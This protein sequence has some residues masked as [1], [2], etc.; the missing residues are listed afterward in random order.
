MSDEGSS[1]VIV[2]GPSGLK[3]ALLDVESVKHHEETVPELLSALLREI[4]RDGVLKHPIIVDEATLVVLDGTHR[5]EALK[6]LGCKRV[7]ACLVDYSDPRIRLGCWYRTL[8]GLDSLL[9][10]VEKLKYK[11][12]FQL[13][14]CHEIKPEELGKPPIALAL[15]DG[16]RYV[17][18]VAEFKDKR[19]A[20]ELA[21]LLEKAIRELG[22]E[23]GF[24][25]EEDAMSK[26]RGGEVD[27]VLMTPRVLK[28]DVISTACSGH[29][30][31]HKTTRHEI[32][33][34]PLFLNAPL[35]LLRADRSRGE[36]R[37][38]LLKLVSAKKARRLPP[39]SVVDGRRY[40][41][42]IIILE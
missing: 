2:P 27:A 41:E 39:G 38:E 40:K 29:V 4:E 5:V 15:T 8:K 20:W 25:V 33:D 30:F 17:R 34:R 14:E 36:L 35:E 31:P 9:G 6:A 26:L 42:P 1:P 7:A 16:K 22:V 21:K 10:L 3:I 32:P 13:E 11:F 24:E 12:G 28:E 23:V 37:A 18:L 19:E